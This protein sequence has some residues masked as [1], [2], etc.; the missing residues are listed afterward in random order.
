MRVISAEITGSLRSRRISRGNPDARCFCGNNRFANAHGASR[1]GTMFPH[2]PPPVSDGVAA[3]KI[4]QKRN[5]T[6]KP[7]KGRSRD[8]I[9]F[10][11]LAQSLP[12]RIGTT[13]YIVLVL[14]GGTRGRS[15]MAS[16][17][18]FSTSKSN[19]R[20]GR[21][22]PSPLHGEI[23]HA[24]ALPQKQTA[25]A[26][27]SNSPAGRNGVSPPWSPPPSLCRAE[28]PGGCPC[29]PGRPC[30]RCPPSIHRNS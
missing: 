27:S 13:V 29:T 25:P 2:V 9:G 11:R 17:G 14:R 6:A 20:P 23:S 7:K 28:S 5:R 3:A 21:G 26:P 1:G 18:Y 8:E 10:V 24:A 19:A 12:A 16:F 30:R 22:K 15:P 4:A